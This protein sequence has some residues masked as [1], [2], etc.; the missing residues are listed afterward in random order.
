MSISKWYFLTR[1]SPCYQNAAMKEVTKMLDISRLIKKLKLAG[2]NL[3][4]YND[5]NDI[6]IEDPQTLVDYREKKN[7]L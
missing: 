1:F 2:R 6:K 3:K 5:K 7:R 4:R